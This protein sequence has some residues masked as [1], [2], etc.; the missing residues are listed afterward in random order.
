[1]QCESV[2]SVD[3]RYD[4]SRKQYPLIRLMQDPRVIRET[5]QKMSDPISSNP[6]VERVR[7]RIERVRNRV[8]DSL[9][10]NLDPQTPED[11][12]LLEIT[13]E[14]IGR[15]GL[16][17]SRL[18]QI[19]WSESVA[20]ASGTMYCPYVYT[21]VP[22]DCPAFMRGVRGVSTIVFFK[23]MRGW[24]TPEQWR[25]LIASSLVHLTSPVSRKRKSRILRRVLLPLTLIGF[26]SEAV[27]YIFSPVLMIFLLI[28][29][30]TVSVLA[31]VVLTSSMD[32]MSWLE[33]DKYTAETIGREALMASLVKIESGGLSD[34]EQLERGQS[35]SNSPSITQ[36]IQNLQSYG[37]SL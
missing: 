23:K 20:E 19:A 36:R 3:T 18:K 25:P 13:N 9:R 8:R 12:Q 28:P 37:S 11:F 17:M 2:P 34:D 30:L 1:L 35:R 5:G 27:A 7:D 26:V 21:P 6:A 14:L 29:L 31:A 10:D 22:P 16:D 33:A 4:P 24:L 15:L 32:R